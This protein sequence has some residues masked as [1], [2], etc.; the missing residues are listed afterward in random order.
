MDPIYKIICLGALIVVMCWL[1]ST[2][3]TLI[4]GNKPGKD[5]KLFNK[6]IFWCLFV[7]V[8][9]TTVGTL[10]LF[11]LKAHHLIWRQ[12]R[13]S[14]LF[15]RERSNYCSALSRAAVRENA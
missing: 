10:I 1:I 2:S 4:P 8:V 15:E 14:V 9:G 5:A 13:Q 11:W 3:G 6:L 7:P 12:S